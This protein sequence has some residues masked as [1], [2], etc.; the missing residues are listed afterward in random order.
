MTRDAAAEA[1]V[2]RRHI[3]WSGISFGV[4]LGV[5][6]AGALVDIFAIHPKTLAVLALPFYVAGTLIVKFAP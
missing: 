2:L 3:Y 6:L 1:R 5:V 4:A